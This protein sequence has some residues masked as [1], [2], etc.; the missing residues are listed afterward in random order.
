MFLL[1]TRCRG[2]I[3]P[4]QFTVFEGCYSANCILLPNLLN[5]PW[6]I[7]CFRFLPY[8]LHTT[9]LWFMVP[10]REVILYL[11]FSYFQ[12]LFN[13]I[14]VL[15]ASLIWGCKSRRCQKKW[16]DFYCSSHI[17]TVF[18][19][20]SYCILELGIKRKITKLWNFTLGRVSS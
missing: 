10:I 6:K 7:T 16:R 15:H 8:T 9:Q 14:L 18:C 13:L 12:I 2:I 20:V 19:T 11:Y 4:A 3:P 5:S 17:W 1:R